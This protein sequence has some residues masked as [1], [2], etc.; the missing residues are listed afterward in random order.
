[1]H[2]TVPPAIEALPAILAAQEKHAAVPISER[3]KRA[4]DPETKLYLKALGAAFVE[5]TGRKKAGVT[6]NRHGPEKFSGAYVTLAREI[7]LH[8]GTKIAL[9]QTPTRLLR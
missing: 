6:T 1:M 2:M 7:D 9:N 5:I 8:Y 3:R 4:R